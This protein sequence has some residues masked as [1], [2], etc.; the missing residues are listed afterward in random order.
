MAINPRKRVENPSKSPQ[1]SRENILNPPALQGTLRQV[2]S[3]SAKL[4]ANFIS[5][6]KNTRQQP[7][8]IPFAVKKTEPIITDRWLAEPASSCQS[9]GF[10]SA[11]L[12]KGKPQPVLPRPASATPQQPV[13]PSKPDA[14]SDGNGLCG[15]Q[16][17]R[18]PAKMAYFFSSNVGAVGR[19][20]LGKAVPAYFTNQPVSWPASRP[21]IERR[22]NEHV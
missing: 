2:N 17:F 21:S 4:F 11:I 9:D 1:G 19:P 22:S 6:G 20:V 12:S 10:G 18:R 5:P 3:V 8:F 15:A 14:L 7:Q 16:T 13:Q